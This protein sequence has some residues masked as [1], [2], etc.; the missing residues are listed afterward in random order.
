MAPTRSKNPNA[1]TRSEGSGP[2][3]RVRSKTTEM[4]AA[5][6]MEPLAFY[7]LVMNQNQA[8]PVWWLYSASSS[9]PERLQ[10]A[11]CYEDPPKGIPRSTFV[12]VSSTPLASPIPP[13][14]DGA[15]LPEGGTIYGLRHV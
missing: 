6:V 1:A 12:A 15:G 14:R 9:T 3:R 4:L 2:R 11:V 8:D 10:Q 13:C 7:I 5:E